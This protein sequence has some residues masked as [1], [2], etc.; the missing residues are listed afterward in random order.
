MVALYD[1]GNVRD[2]PF[3]EIWTDTSDPIMAGLKRTAAAVGAVGACIHRFEIC[4]GNTRVRA[5]QLTGD[6]WAE[7]P[8]CYLTDAGNR[9]RRTRRGKSNDRASG[10][11]DGP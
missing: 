11:I 4:G 10:R 6:P 7:D 9:R 8:G 1:L 5:W 3:S 2:R